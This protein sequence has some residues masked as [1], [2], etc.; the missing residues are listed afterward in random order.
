MATT[1]KL[2]GTPIELPQA[3]PKRK[4]SGASGRNAQPQRLLRA[5]PELWELID[6]AVSH[7]G[8]SYSDWSRAALKRQAELEL[9][10]EAS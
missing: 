6:R 8:I 1:K 3:R 5:A 7:A 2:S 9:K 4:R 10:R